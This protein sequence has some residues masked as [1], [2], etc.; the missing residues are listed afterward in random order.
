[1]LQ[2]GRPVPIWAILPL[3]V[4]LITASI[5]IGF[6][7]G[8]RARNH[9]HETESLA[10]EIATPAMALLGLMLAF[11]FGWAATR[12]DNRL[13]SRLEEAQ[14]LTNVYRLADFAEPGDRDRVRQ[15][16]RE[17]I[18]VSVSAQD[19]SAFQHA[20]AQR[21]ALHR[22][23]WAIAVR[24]GQA[25]PSSEIVAHFVSAMN[26][27]LNSHLERSVQAISSRIPVGIVFGLA[28]ILVMTMG[29]LGYQMGLTMA[30]RSRA[31]IPLI[32]SITIVVYIILDLDRP[33]EGVL[34]V[35]DRALIEAQRELGAW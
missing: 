29:M 28:V 25:K 33:L 11:T 22:E 7:F 3:I 27:L 1:M 6:R 21:E 24:T 17:Y 4:L 35:R 32:L 15:L 8:R 12:F 23:L 16:L 30:V 20:F 14:A 9:P 34:R 5:E 26:D 10:A 31:L 2:L 18:A 13:S 19:V